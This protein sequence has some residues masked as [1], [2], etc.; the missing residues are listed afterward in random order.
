MQKSEIIV[1]I[2]H[3][4]K[5]E[6]LCLDSFK[7]QLFKVK[8]GYICSSCGTD[9]GG[10][11][12]NCL[13]CGCKFD[14]TVTVRCNT[15]YKNYYEEAWANAIYKTSDR[16][17]MIG[18][19]VTKH[20]DRLYHQEVIEAHEVQ[21][22][23]ILDGVTYTYSRA[24]HNERWFDCPYGDYYYGGGAQKLNRKRVNIE[25]E[26]YK[27]FLSDTKLRYT[28]VWEHIKNESLPISFRYISNAAKYPWVEMLHKSGMT[29]LCEQVLNGSADM[30][31]IRPDFI[32]KLNKETRKMNL[33]YEGLYAIKKFESAGI[34]YDLDS[35]KQFESREFVSSI[36]KAHKI[37]NQN[38]LKIMR[39]LKHQREALKQDILT[40][41]DDYLNMMVKSNIKP[42]TELLAFPR[43]LKQAHDN[44]VKV[45]NAI[46][47]KIK[48]DK[49]KNS[50]ERLKKLDY[51]SGGLIIT[52]PSDVNQI[53]EEGKA[54]HHCVGTYV[55]RVIDGTT[56]ILFI[57]KAD[58]QNKPY[59]TLEYKNNQVI[60]CRGLKNKSMTG[61]IKEFVDE[62]Q[63]HLKKKSR[64]ARN[65][66]TVIPMMVAA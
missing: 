28:M 65:Q 45:F 16:I 12:W 3:N 43:D 54:L 63:K 46:Q 64:K 27:E 21:R 15:N 20:I 62:W 11:Y 36:F 66:E 49:Y 13:K 61:E 47:N 32:K 51:R 38:P 25:P 30:R 10:D 58:D 52:V 34:K 14:K 33:G 35:I 4:P 50:Y 40:V 60:Q 37:T 6:T 29:V 42:D 8:D 39:Y 53:L 57:R 5:I 56:S 2:E 41:Y 31:I 9:I 26:S 24:I 59:Y 19:I 22:D 17:V 23:T 44:A 55:D 48:N 1:P 7:H 18:Y